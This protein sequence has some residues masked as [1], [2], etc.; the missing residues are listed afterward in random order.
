MNPV[1]KEEL[2][3]FIYTEARLLDEGHYDD[4][5]ALWLPD[6]HYG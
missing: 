3:D 6:G 4:W 2:I 1:T 5:L